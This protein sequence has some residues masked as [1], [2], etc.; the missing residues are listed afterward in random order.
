[1]RTYRFVH[2]ADLHLDSPFRGMLR[3]APDAAHILREATFHTY[4]AIIDLCIEERVDAL[5]VAGDI[6][7]GAERSLR[8]QLR[9]IEG[10]RRLDEAGIRAFVCHG[11]HDPLDGW[12]ARVAFPPNTVRFGPD[13]EAHP[14]D[15]N[16]PQSP[17]VYG[18]SYPTREVRENLVP[19]FPPPEAGRRAIALLHANVGTDTGH[20]PYAPCTLEDLERTRYDYWALGH[21]HTRQ[22]LRSQD[23]AVVY[24]G[25][26]QG[27]H[28]NEPGARG[29]YLV[30]IDERGGV[31]L[32]FRPLD[33]VRWAR[34]EVDI[35]TI[36]ESETALL[37]DALLD[38]LTSAVES[39]RDDAE[40]RPL[41]YR[42]QVT[43]RGPAHASLARPEFVPDIRQGL[44]ERFSSGA[45]FAF[46]ERIEV[47]TAAAADRDALA[48]TPDLLGDLLRLIDELAADPAGM[49]ELRRELTPLYAH[50]RA[51]RYLGNGALEAVD[52]A[53]LLTDAERILLDEFLD[54]GAR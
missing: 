23:P 52:I 18:I 25:N 7:D 43:G 30:E 34:V 27:R 21:V 6:Y 26:P 40:G 15:P 39:A 17:M 1:V 14:G 2:A 54:A 37:D 8:A 4:E 36:T 20:D 49:E 50:T 22:V 35:G 38:A 48:Q 13:V 12:E 9:F 41:V 47:A 3:D 33:T 46:C 29:V 28:A 11:N 44:N 19:R 24:P 31:T 16:D 53:A 32:D 51:R 45:T 5:L 10:L 42:L